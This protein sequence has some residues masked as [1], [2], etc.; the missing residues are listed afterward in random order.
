[1][2]QPERKEFTPRAYSGLITDFICDTRRGMLMAD[3]GM[4]KT[5]GGLTAY[6]MLLFSGHETKPLLV[7]APLRVARSVWLDE[8]KKW[9]HLSN[10]IV[11]PIVGSVD[12][13]RAA[14]RKDASVYTIN[15]ENIPWLIEEL[16]DRWPFGMIIPDESTRLAGLRISIR[17]SKK[18]KKYAQGQ[19]T[20]R[21]RKLAKMAWQHRGSRWMNLSGTPA[22]NGLKK[23]YGQVWYCDFGARLGNSYTAFQNRYFTIERDGYKLVPLPGSDRLIHNAIKDICM[24]VLAKDYF[25]LREPI[26]VPVRVELPTKARMLYR[27]ME[28]ELFL[29]VGDRKVEAKNAGSKAMKLLQLASGA[30]YLDPETIDDSDPRA[31]E[32]AEVHDEKILALQSIV[33]ESGGVPLIVAYQFRSDEERLRKAF[34]KMRFLE[35]KKDE[36]DFKAGKVQM[37]GIHPASGG[38]GIDGFQHVTNRIC[39]FSQWP[40]YE[41]RDQ[42]IG[43]IGPVRQFQAGYERPVYIYDIIATGTR[44]EDVI[45]SHVSKRETQDF[46]L[47]AMRR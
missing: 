16:G 1:M 46:L 9:N 22:P 10:I 20:L 32:W 23:L 17:I 6:D 12:E 2:L 31:K 35:T 42:L 40:D 26:A 24:S 7:V 29:Q 14:L 47:E 25:D 30:I 18:G 34:P 37:I 11:S 39:F 27:R 44:D 5:V 21:A 38:H 36:D 19:G 8:S 28:K 43:R 15:Y 13:R 45:E 41:L 4:G 33:E 3:M